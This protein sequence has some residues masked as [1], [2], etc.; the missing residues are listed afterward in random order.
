VFSPKNFSRSDAG[1]V[2]LAEGRIRC[3]VMR[4]VPGSPG[5]LVGTDIAGDVSEVQSVELGA[6]ACAQ[7]SRFPCREVIAHGAMGHLDAAIRGERRALVGRD[8]RR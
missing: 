5:S 4:G 8:Q 7:Q 3:T 1:A 2:S 6:G